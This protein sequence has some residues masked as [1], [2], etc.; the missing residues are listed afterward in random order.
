MSTPNNVNLFHKVFAWEQRRAGVPV[1]KYMG[2]SLAGP[3]SGLVSRRHFQFF[4]GIC[5][6]A[7]TLSQA[8]G[9]IASGNSGPSRRQKVWAGEMGATVVASEQTPATAAEEEEEGAC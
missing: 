6:G 3:I 5:A 4:Q 9:N 8:G 7:K 1:Q 2:S